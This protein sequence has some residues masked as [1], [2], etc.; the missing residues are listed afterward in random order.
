MLLSATASSALAEPV[1]CLVGQP[2]PKGPSS[3][4]FSIRN[5]NRVYVGVFVIDAEAV[6]HPSG[7]K[8]LPPR[9]T[10]VPKYEITNSK[11]PLPQKIQLWAK[12]VVPV[13]SR[14]AHALDQSS[15]CSREGSFKSLE[16]FEQYER[17][18]VDELLAKDT[19]SVQAAVVHLYVGSLE[20]TYRNAS[21][22]VF[23]GCDYVLFIA[24]PV[25]YEL[26]L[27]PGD[28]YPIE[29]YRRFKQ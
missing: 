9:V 2:C 21:M 25:S 19:H 20:R 1:A 29:V 8:S 6:T 10:F 23:E 12:T 4:E 28:L 7:A 11:E 13:T 27:S 24:D 16:E 22:L 5:F 3:L 15:L 17:S 14:S 26:P 18:A